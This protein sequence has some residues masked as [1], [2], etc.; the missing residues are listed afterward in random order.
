VFEIALSVAACRRAGTRVDVAW[1]IGTE[2][3]L[4]V[5]P[6][7]AVAITP[8]GG[9]LGSVLSGALDDQLGELAAL[10]ASTGRV[11]ELEIGASEAVLAGLEPGTRATV[12]LAPASSLPDDTWDLLLRREPVCLV[13]HLD[14][15]VVT[16]TDLHTAATITDAGDDAA[17]AF[18]RGSS[19]VLTAQEAVTT[20]LR[21]TPSLV[22]VGGRA[23][24]V[25]ALERQA[26]LVGWRPRATQ[27]AAEV[28]GLVAGL[29]GLDGVVVMGHDLETTGRALLAALSSDVGYLGSVGPGDVRRARADW[30]AYRGVSDLTRVHSPAGLDI[31]AR[32]PAEIA[33]AIT[34]E[35]V[36]AR[37]S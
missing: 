8:G 23:D 2:P 7:D 11:V 27:S 20:I 10:Q 35:M 14:G 33:M 1:V 4:A 12:L 17:R 32:T 13:S 26:S 15:D 6:E 37:H 29:T 34:A 9:R 16:R 3:P 36:A 28:E 21:P 31:G 24:M 5:G 22:I 30:L 18:D 25:E 19:Q